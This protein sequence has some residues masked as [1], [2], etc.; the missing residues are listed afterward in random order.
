MQTV[1]PNLKI[2][3]TR[4]LDTAYLH[5]ENQKPSTVLFLH[6]FPDTPYIWNDQIDHFSKNYNVIAPFNRGVLKSQ[7]TTNKDRYSVKSMAMDV[8]EII[9]ASKTNSVFIVG[10]DIGGLIAHQTAS[11]LQQKCSGLVLINSIP[12]GIAANRIK[13]SLH[14]IKRS[15]YI[16][17]LIS[18]LGKLATSYFPQSSHA[19]AHRLGKNTIKS[20]DFH[21]S[22]INESLKVY[23]TTLKNIFIKKAPYYTPN[24]EALYV[25][26]HQDPFV[27]PLKKQDLSPSTLKKTQ[28]RILKGAH[29]LQQTNP[30]EIN[31]LIE[32]FVCKSI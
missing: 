16:P 8:L 3:K 26:G 18:P 17:M 15:W 27:L 19:L 2:I 23:G 5:I 14:Q 13:S 28:L 10:H 29:W 21:P 31:K 6:G 30:K 9:A 32:D 7:S 1:E 24:C 22:Q 25:F 11:H 20:K 12:M 4:G